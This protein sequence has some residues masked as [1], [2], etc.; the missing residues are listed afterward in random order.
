MR[1]NSYLS[2][3]SD[4]KGGGRYIEEPALVEN[5]VFQTR[6]GPL[7]PFEDALALAMTAAFD[8]GAFEFAELVA[9]LNA[10]DSCDRD[11]AA[12][13]EASLDAELDRLSEALFQ[14]VS[15]EIAA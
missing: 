5:I 1:Y 8:S 11:G 12:W 2:G 14:K 4:P 13:T 6:G 3:T 9:D 10:A 7:D 15:E